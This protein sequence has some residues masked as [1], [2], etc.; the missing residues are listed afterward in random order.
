M[1]KPRFQ[2][3]RNRLSLDGRSYKVTLETGTGWREG[4]W[5]ILQPTT[6]IKPH[7][8]AVNYYQ[9]VLTSR[10]SNQQGWALW[11]FS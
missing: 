9:T 6:Y 2:T 11:T 3:R 8:Q 4:L 7:K 10:E 5:P 1:T